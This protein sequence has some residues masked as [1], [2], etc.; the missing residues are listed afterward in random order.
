MILKYSVGNDISYKDF[1]SCILT[2]DDKQQ[3]KVKASRKFDNSPS[4]FKAYKEWYEKNHRDRSIPMHFCLEA[5]GVYHEELSYFIHGEGHRVSIILANHSNKYLESLGIKTKNDKIDARGLAQMG[6]E[7]SLKK[8]D[9]PVEFYAT[10]R[11]LTRHYQSLQELKTAENNRLHAMK[12]A[13]HKVP[14]VIRQMKQSIN[15]I[16]KQ[17]KKTSTEISIHLKKDKDVNRKVEQI[18][19]IKGVAEL[20]VAVVIGETYGFELFENA[21]QL[22]SYTGYDVIENQSGQRQGK[23]KISKKGN[24]RIRRA[25]HLPA[26]NVKKHEPVF[27]NLFDRTFEKH[28]IKMKSYVA[29]QR[30]LLTT[31]FALWKND[32]AFD[33][34][35]YLKMKGNFESEQGKIV[36]LGSPKATPGTKSF[37]PI[38]Q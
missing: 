1:K 9:P 10:L 34:E 15:H 35:Y 5:T 16:K 38:V 28:K 13:K 11:T 37:E 19:E 27:K 6:A 24:S 20:T 22:T 18:C 12:V 30:K 23:T 8:W 32:E 7:R 2:I 17:I 14:S 25:L 3:V 33:S 26:F 31:I 36:A 21:K 29:I 4:G